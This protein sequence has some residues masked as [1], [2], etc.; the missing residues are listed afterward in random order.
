MPV[1]FL[2][3][4][5]HIGLAVPA[6]AIPESDPIYG[7]PPIGLREDLV[8]EHPRIF[9]D[10][11]RLEAIRAFYLNP[12]SGAN[13]FKAELDAYAT[14]TRNAGTTVDFLTNA[15]NAQRYGMW[16]L[17]T[18]ALHAVDRRARVRGAVE[19]S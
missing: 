15:T 8:G 13:R 1:A 5:I 4:F 9:F 14:G 16:R 2:S 18:V 10:A 17:P 12:G 19:A 11:E 6:T 3:I 7:G